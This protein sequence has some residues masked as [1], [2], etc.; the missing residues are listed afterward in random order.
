MYRIVVAPLAKTDGRRHQAIAERFGHV[1]DHEPGIDAPA[2]KR[3]ERHLAFEPISYRLAE[4]DTDVFDERVRVPVIGIEFRD[5]PVLPCDEL[6]AGGKQPVSRLQFEDILEHRS[7]SG[8][9]T[10]GQI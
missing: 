6:L 7:R 8:N 2:E 3:P 4:R 5:I 9:I 1:R 10:Q